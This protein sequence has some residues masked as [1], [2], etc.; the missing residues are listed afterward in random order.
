[1]QYVV[2]TDNS[3]ASASII[4][5]LETVKS[6]VKVLALPASMPKTKVSA[7][8]SSEA[9]SDAQAMAFIESLSVKNGHRVPAD[10]R[11]IEARTDKY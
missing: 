2:T 3:I 10:E 9:V 5:V 7:A 1:M 11:G 8:V 4:H 6:V